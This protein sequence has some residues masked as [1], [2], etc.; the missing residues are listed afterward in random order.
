MIGSPQFE[1]FET[2][3]VEGRDAAG[4]TE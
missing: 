4:G 1:G 2:V 3:L